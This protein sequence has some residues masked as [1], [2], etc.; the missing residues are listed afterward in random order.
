MNQF[1]SVNF[2]LK[3]LNFKTFDPSEIFYLIISVMFLISV[4]LYFLIWS[5]PLRLSQVFIGKTLYR[6]VK[7][8]LLEVELQIEKKG[9]SPNLQ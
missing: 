5:E 7:R 3:I 1:C 9:H 6:I 4:K 2:I 8:C